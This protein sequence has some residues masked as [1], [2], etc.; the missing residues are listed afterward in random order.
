[1]TSSRPYL[2]RAIYDWITDNGLTPYLLVDATIEG[3]DVPRRYVENG[4]IVLNIAPSAT[5]ALSL[6]S[7]A[8]EFSARFGG[9]PVHLYIPVTAVMAIYARENG[10]GMMFNEEG[11]GGDGGGG[12]GRSTEREKSSSSR[13][14]LKV[15]K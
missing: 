10:Q 11:G 7:D 6:G 1:M 15:I 2:I 8:V 5:A 12:E 4:R 14:Q 13:P 3:V 9:T